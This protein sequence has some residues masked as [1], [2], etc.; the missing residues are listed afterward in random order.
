MGNRRKGTAAPDPGSRVAANGKFALITNEKLIALYT[1][2]LKCRELTRRPGA[3]G[4]SGMMRGHEAVLVAATIDLGPGDAVCSR[5][6]GALTGFVV[7]A[8]IANIFLGPGNHP[9]GKVR[10]KMAAGMMG[11][12]PSA[13]THG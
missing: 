7:G 6:H 4:R 12:S 3:T 5:K 2:L 13:H 1:N 9:S 10:G 11:A 8:T